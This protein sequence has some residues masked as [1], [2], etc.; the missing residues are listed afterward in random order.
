MEQALA[1][2]EQTDITVREAAKMYDVSPSTLHDRESS[3]WSKPGPLPYLTFAEEEKL[4]KFLYPHT[5]PQVVALVQRIV[6]SK[7]LRKT[8]SRVVVK[9]LSSA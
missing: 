4:I 5:R 8:V 9:G 2:V 6:D 7:Q 3:P 1:L